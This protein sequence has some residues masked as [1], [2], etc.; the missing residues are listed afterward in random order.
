MKSGNYILFGTY[1]GTYINIY[2]YTSKH[3][4]LAKVNLSETY[5]ESV[6]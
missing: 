4:A 2:I 1:T 5:D 3:T 6:S